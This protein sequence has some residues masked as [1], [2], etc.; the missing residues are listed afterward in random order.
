MYIFQTFFLLTRTD[1][2]WYATNRQMTLRNIALVLCRRSLRCFLSSQSGSPPRDR[3]TRSDRPSR[4]HFW[5]G[6]ATRLIIVLGESR[7]SASEPSIRYGS[8]PGDPSG[9]RAPLCRRRKDLNPPSAPYAEYSRT[10]WYFDACGQTY[11]VHVYAASF[12]E[13]RRATGD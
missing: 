13:H 2:R 4:I 9:R 7:D 6:T 11:A 10:P 5:D 8:D 3:G 12:I 1:G